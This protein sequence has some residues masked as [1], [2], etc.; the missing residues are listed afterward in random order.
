MWLEHCGSL[1]VLDCLQRKSTKRNFW[2]TMFMLKTHILSGMSH[3]TIWPI[4]PLFRLAFIFIFF[5]CSVSDKVNWEGTLLEDL[6]DGYNKHARPIEDIERPIEVSIAFYLT[7]I[8]NLVSPV[9][10]TAPIPCMNFWRKMFQKILFN[11]YISGMPV[12]QQDAQPSLG[13]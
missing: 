8:L 10:L 4:I 13:Y 6:F 12:R 3:I 5:L 11:Q 2:S 7:K 1:N 9:S